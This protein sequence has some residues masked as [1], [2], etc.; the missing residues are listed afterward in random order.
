ML[1]INNLP[2]MFILGNEGDHLVT[3]FLIDCTEWLSRFPD[4]NLSASILLP[5]SLVPV[6][7]PVT[8]N[9]ATLILAVPRAVTQYPGRSSIVFHLNTPD[10]KTIRSKMVDGY[11]S[12]GHGIINGNL[13]ETGSD[14][15]PT[16][17]ELYFDKLTSKLSIL[18]GNT[19]EL[20]RGLS[21]AQYE[22][23][24]EL[25][26]RPDGQWTLTKGPVY[27]QTSPARDK[28]ERR[29]CRS[30]WGIGIIHLDFVATAVQGEIAYIPANGPKAE[31]LAEFQVYDGGSVWI[32]GGSRTIKGQGLTVDRRYIFNIITYFIN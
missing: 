14:C 24:A 2:D 18:G 22:T 30:L 10:G 4:G 20:N 12:P 31:L 32:D 27:S 7:L 11:V 28:P 16:T 23:L 6:V 8:V 3:T 9:D 25:M 26:T 15:W 13:L 17:P 19:V 21:T 29:F 5:G 1:D